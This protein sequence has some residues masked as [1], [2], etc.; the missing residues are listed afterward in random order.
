MTEDPVPGTRTDP[1]F[2]AARV[3]PWDAPFSCRVV[4]PQGGAAAYGFL[5]DD[6]WAA[7]ADELA[8]LDV[9]VLGGPDG[10][11]VATTDPTAEADTMT[12]VLPS[13]G[14]LLDRAWQDSVQ[15]DLGRN[16][17][18]R[19]DLGEADFDGWV[20]A[21]VLDPA[22]RQHQD[23]GEDAPW[24]YDLLLERLGAVHHG[25]RRLFVWPDSPDS[26]SAGELL[27]APHFPAV[28]EWPDLTGLVPAAA[29]V[30]LDTWSQ[31]EQADVTYRMSLLHRGLDLV[32][33]LRRGTD[34]SYAAR[35]SSQT[36]VELRV[37]SKQLRTRA[38]SAGWQLMGY[39]DALLWPIAVP[40][41]AA[42]P[43]GFVA[44]VAIELLRRATCVALPP[45]PDLALWEERLAELAAL[46]AQQGSR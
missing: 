7:R 1:E 27:G 25:E 45:A 32:E 16:D 4:L 38:A 12:V 42:L 35:V 11:R 24:R 14:S 41:G 8:A 13:L 3:P 10:A 2:S 44:E 43:T 37:F 36:G 6:W 19:N 20:R 18:G 15:D 31:L 5:T 29:A 23:D 22:R 28:P 17:L 21:R 33:I 26:L 9:T 39:A 34:P 30:A 40:P 46:Q